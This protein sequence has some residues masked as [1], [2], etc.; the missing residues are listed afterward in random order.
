MPCEETV[1]EA[2]ELSQWLTSKPREL[3]HSVC[4]TLQQY[5][6]TAAQLTP[7][8]AGLGLVLLVSIIH[9]TAK[10]KRNSFEYS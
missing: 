1:K 5:L 9:K 7:E 8:R 10:G 3:P 4:H 6:R 2:P